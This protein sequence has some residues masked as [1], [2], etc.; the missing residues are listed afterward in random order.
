MAKKNA[1]AAESAEETSAALSTVSNGDVL[2]L[3]AEVLFAD[4][5][6]ALRQNESDSAP[7]SWKLSP[8][9][10]L[11]YILGGKSL[12]ATIGGKKQTV[13]ITRKFFGEASIVER[14]IVTLASTM[15][16][17]PPIGARLGSRTET[18]T[19]SLTRPAWPRGPSRTRP[20][21]PYF[22]VTRLPSMLHSRAVRV[23]SPRCMTPRLSP[24]RPG[25]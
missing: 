12:T 25:S 19:G 2:R 21:K 18:C 20:E 11:A 1:K 16:R 7:L 9:S 17:S 3:P 15:V 22:T 24:A 6:E 5:L 8:R 13:E 10:V 4:Q 23:I 14:S